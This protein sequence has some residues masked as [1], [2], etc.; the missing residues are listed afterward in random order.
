MGTNV[1]QFSDMIG[2]KRGTSDLSAWTQIDPATIGDRD[3]V[4]LCNFS[5][6]YLFLI[7]KGSADSDP[8]GSSTD[9]AD[10]FLA[11]GQ[12]NWFAVGADIE[13]WGLHAAVTTSG[14][15][16]RETK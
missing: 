3:G 2:T 15:G 8:S 6:N 7:F 16:L 13:V 10:T 12:S 11:P 9:D 14:Y 4:L 5:T 1:A